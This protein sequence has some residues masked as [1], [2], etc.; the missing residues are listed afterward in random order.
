VDQL[1][2]PISGASSDTFADASFKSQNA[3]GNTIEIISPGESNTA[4]SLEEDS[5]PITWHRS[6]FPTTADAGTTEDETVALD[7]PNMTSD[8]K[9]DSN[10]YV[11]EFIER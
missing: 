1:L 6:P 11:S 10:Q 5:Q 8:S 3:S 7:L 9:T 2:S 4:T